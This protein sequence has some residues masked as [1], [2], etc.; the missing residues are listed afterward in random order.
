MDMD[1]AVSKDFVSAIQSEFKFQH[2]VLNFAQGFELGGN[3]QTRWRIHP[4]NA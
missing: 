1:D 2:E 4:H 3:G